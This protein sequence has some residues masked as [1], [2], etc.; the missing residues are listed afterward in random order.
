MCKQIVIL[1]VR[2]SRNGMLAVSI[3]V[4]LALKTTIWWVGEAICG[5]INGGMEEI[6]GNDR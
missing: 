5:L 6:Y 4:V 1:T 2:H 3:V